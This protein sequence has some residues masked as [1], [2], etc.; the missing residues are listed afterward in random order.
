MGKKCFN[1]AIFTSHTRIFD[2]LSYAESLPV[3]SDGAHHAW[4][5]E[6]IA[7]KQSLNIETK[8]YY[9]MFY[10]LFGAMM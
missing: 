3:L 1:C 6:E 4:I 7:D 10:H 2:L 9:P 5:M 8:V